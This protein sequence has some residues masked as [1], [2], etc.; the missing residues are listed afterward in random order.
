MWPATSIHNPVHMLVNNNEPWDG[1]IIPETFA[2][3][4][5]P[6][7]SFWY[8]RPCLWNSARVC[9]ASKKLSLISHRNYH[10][11]F[12]F[13]CVNFILRQCSIHSNFVLGGLL[14]SMS[15]MSSVVQWL[16]LIKVARCSF[17]EPYWWLKVRIF[18][19]FCKWWVE[20]CFHKW[21]I[22]WIESWISCSFKACNIS[23]RDTVFNVFTTLGVI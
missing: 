2:M 8:V 5:Y 11:L 13:W 12:L 15:C 1:K 14:S 21:D 23:S 20:R 10:L 18:D 7:C 9:K 19:S 6:S 4:L 17:M 22:F 16:L 3:N